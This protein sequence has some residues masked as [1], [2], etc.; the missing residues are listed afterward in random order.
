MVENSSGPAAIDWAAR[1]AAVLLEMES[2]QNAHPGRTWEHK[3]GRFFIRA[4]RITFGFALAI[5]GLLAMGESPSVSEV[6][7]AALT[8][9]ALAGAV[10]GVGFGLW[11]L[12]LAWISAFGAGPTNEEKKNALRRTA[13]GNV[14]LRARGLGGRY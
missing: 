14:D 3:A 7:F 4:L 12:Y 10:A 1:E 9:K 2:L 13:E 6:P 8:L 5:A 11:L